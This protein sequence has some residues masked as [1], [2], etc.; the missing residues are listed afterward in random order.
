M[1]TRFVSRVAYNKAK[2]TYK[3]NFVMKC[4]FRK[5][6]YNIFKKLFTEN[7]DILYSFAESMLE[8]TRKS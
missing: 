7:E 5:T 2:Y 6:G 4:N 8:I 1:M 3:K